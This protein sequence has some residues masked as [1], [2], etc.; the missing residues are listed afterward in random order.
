MRIS[1]AHDTTYAYAIPARAVVQILRLTP[2][3]HEGMRVMRWRVE[4]DVDGRLRLGEDSLGNI[5]H[6]LSLAGPLAGV[7]VSVNGEVETVDTQGVVRG[8]V[9]RFPDAVYLRTTPLTEADSAIRDFADGLL[10]DHGP[11]SLALLHGLL[12]GIHRDIAFDP[13]PTEVTTTAAEAFALRRGVC[14]DL[15]HIFI[16]AARHLGIPTRYVS[17]HFMRNDG[18]TAQDAAHAWVEAKVPDLG[19]VGFDPA[20]GISPT[21]AHVRVAI[22]LDYLGAA[23]VRGSRYGGGEE[24]MDVKLTVQKAAQWQAQA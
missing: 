10:A 16:A 6:T 7:T 20:N 8:T 12:T 2:R 24:R 13:H 5:T 1:I 23:P 4:V 15:S 19:W 22:G 18:V 14:Q 21:D 3:S 11:D 17:G 9:E